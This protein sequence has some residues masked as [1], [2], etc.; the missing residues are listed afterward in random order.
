MLPCVVLRE[1]QRAD[2]RDRGPTRMIYAFFG[3][4]KLV[5][6]S[7]LDRERGTASS[8]LAFLGVGDGSV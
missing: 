7:S 8:A 1:A 6:L 4:D 2:G 3:G 5:G